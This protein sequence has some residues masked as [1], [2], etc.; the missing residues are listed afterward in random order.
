VI[1][2]VDENYITYQGTHIYR[3][4][5]FIPT[6]ITS[7]APRLRFLAARQ[8]ALDPT[9]QDFDVYDWVNTAWINYTRTYPTGSFHVYARL[10]GGNG[11]FNPTLGTV[12]S[13]WGTPTQTVQP[14]GTFKG[15]GTSFT[16]WQ[17]VELIDTNTLAPIT[18]NLS[19][20]NTLR[21]TTDGNVNANFYMLVPVA[22]P[23]ALHAVISGGTIQISFATQNGFSYTISTKNSLSDA[24][25]TPLTTI[26]GD[27]TTHTVNDGTA[28][29]SRFYQLS[30]K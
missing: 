22:A 19:G 12:T 3:P 11:A 15:T 4:A 25:W 20:T 28:Q 26:P 16:T 24:T 14:L 9:I 23:S 13:G 10:A 18:V 6:E 27:G 1:P 21:V 5:D 8:A 2:G 7:D 17:Y 29:T 30:V